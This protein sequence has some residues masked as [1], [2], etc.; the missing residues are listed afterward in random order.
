MKNSRMIKWQAVFS[1]E[2]LLCVSYYL[3]FYI[4]DLIL[5]ITWGGRYIII[6][7]CQRGNWSLERNVR[8]LFLWC[9]FSCFLWT[10]KWPISSE[11]IMSGQIALTF[12][13][14]IKYNVGKPLCKGC[15][16]LHWWGYLS[17]RCTL[18]IIIACGCRIISMLRDL[19]FS[20]LVSAAETVNVTVLKIFFI[21][22]IKGWLSIQL[23]S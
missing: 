21:V 17:I 5:T 13:G 10:S 23:V 19:F 15:P 14:K 12:K 22:L 8:D 11:H 1:L 16:S 3:K 2:Y 6:A 9:S 4:D 18:M 7:I 20:P